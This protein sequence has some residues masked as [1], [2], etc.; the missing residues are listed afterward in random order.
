[1]GIFSNLLFFLL[2]A[3]FIIAIIFAIKSDKEDMKKVGQ[4]R[5]VTTV[6]HEPR[7]KYNFPFIRVYYANGENEVFD[8]ENVSILKTQGEPKMIYRD[9]GGHLGAELHLPPELLV[10]NK[11]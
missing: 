3:G 11:A 10:L 8:A 2:L 6:V 4:T 7:G 5:E 9:F 1:M